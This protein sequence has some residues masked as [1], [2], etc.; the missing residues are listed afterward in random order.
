LPC[1][2]PSRFNAAQTELLFFAPSALPN[3]ARESVADDDRVVSAVRAPP[4]R[5]ATPV[6]ALSCASGVVDRERDGII[7]DEVV[8]RKRV[9]AA[10]RVVEA[11]IIRSILVGE[12]VHMASRICW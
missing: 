10:K 1:E 9:S 2:S 11:R 4:S 7:V 6:A 5:V 3:L 8:E 12:R